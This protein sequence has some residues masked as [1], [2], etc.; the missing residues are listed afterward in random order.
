MS[1]HLPALASSTATRRSISPRTW[2]SFSSP[3]PSLRSAATDFSRNSIAWSREPPSRPSLSA[4][5]ARLPC[6]VARRRRSTGPRPP[7]R[8]S[9]HRCRRACAT[10]SSGCVPAARPFRKGRSRHLRGA[11]RPTRGSQRQ[12]PHSVRRCV[13]VHVARS[14]SMAGKMQPRPG[15]D[16]RNRRQ[17]LPSAGAP[18]ADAARR[19]GALWRQVSRALSGARLVGRA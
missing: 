2:S 11:R 13:R 19:P 14:W 10:R 15:K 8:R 9:R 16:C 17:N 6:F 12:R 3:E 5:S 1:G 4:S 7:A 18:R